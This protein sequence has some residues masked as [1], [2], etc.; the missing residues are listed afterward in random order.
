M[1]YLTITVHIASNTRPVNK[2][3]RAGHSLFEAQPR[4]HNIT[5]THTHRSHHTSHDTHSHTCLQPH[6]F[7]F[8]KNPKDRNLI[9][10]SV[11]R[12]CNRYVLVPCRTPGRPNVR[13]AEFMPSGPSPPASVPTN[14]TSLSLMKGWNIPDRCGSRPKNN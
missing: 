6:T 3:L 14:R 5:A 4:W 1:Y 12:T 10:K 11:K 7:I 2:Q 13:V 8:Y 9:I